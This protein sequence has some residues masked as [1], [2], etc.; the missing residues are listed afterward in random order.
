MKSLPKFATLVP[1]KNWM[2]KLSIF[3]VLLLVFTGCSEPKDDHSTIRIA[4]AANMQFAMDSI[5]VLFEKESGIKC[6]IASNSSGMLTAQIEKGAPFD[7][8]VSA[9]MVYPNKLVESGFA[10]SPS[11][12][13]YGRLALLSNKDN[14]FKTITEVLSSE[15]VKRIA[16]ADPNTAPY[17]MATVEYLEH[18]KLFEK[19]K[20]KIIYG[21]SIGQV[22]QYLT[23]GAVDAA[24][25]SYSF[26][27]KFGEEYGI[28]EV[29][30]DNFSDIKQGVVILK[31]GKKHKPDE[32]EKF[33]EFLKSETCQDVLKHFGY[34]IN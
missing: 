3:I 25:T 12:Y 14:N 29:D 22:N 13:A 19:Y 1:L 9:N 16:I 10:D 2:Y 8:F 28:I 7:V 15:S 30:S 33:V 17:G 32:S 5:S 24:F 23:T 18:K 11:V 4:T 20:D 26:V 31:H 6:E 21:E 27:T 34:R